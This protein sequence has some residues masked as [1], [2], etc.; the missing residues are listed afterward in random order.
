MI[1]ARVRWSAPYDEIQVVPPG[2]PPIV[3]RRNRAAV[4]PV[5]WWARSRWA[6]LAQA[7][8]EPAAPSTGLVESI[9]EDSEAY[10]GEVDQLRRLAWVVNVVVLMALLG[11]WQLLLKLGGP[12]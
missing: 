2:Q 11:L 6:S 10:R 5:G 3:A 4:A 12:S 7:L 8:L 1:E 9:V